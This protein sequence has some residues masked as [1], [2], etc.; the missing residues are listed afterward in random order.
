MT[1]AGIESTLRAWEMRR[2][3][4][5][6]GAYAEEKTTALGLHPRQLGGLSCSEAM[7]CRHVVAEDPASQSPATES[8][9]WRV[10]LRPRIV[11]RGGLF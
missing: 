9:R 4:Y 1:W 2:A 6:P 8:K 3:T 11:P 10:R 5:V 7:T